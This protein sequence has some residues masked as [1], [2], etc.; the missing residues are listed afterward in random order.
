VAY[1]WHFMQLIRRLTMKKGLSADALNPDSFH[2]KSR[3]SY[4]K[5]QIKDKNRRKQTTKNRKG[6]TKDRIHSSMLRENTLR[7]LRTE[8]IDNANL[9]A[10]Y[11]MYE[12]LQDHG[13]QQALHSS[14]VKTLTR[15]EIEKIAHTITPINNIKSES[16][17]TAIN[18]VCCDNGDFDNLEGFDVIETIDFY[19]DFFD[20][21]TPSTFE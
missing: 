10:S 16:M 7:N 1:K 21:E 11:M 8:L 4:I 12:I 2:I 3:I 6:L 14:A 9:G 20:S 18:D 19:N 5:E 15:A 13:V 17:P